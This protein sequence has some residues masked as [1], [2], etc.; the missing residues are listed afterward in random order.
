MKDSV[1]PFH[2]AVLFVVHSY[3]FE[4]LI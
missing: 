1:F 4:L 3:P 2:V